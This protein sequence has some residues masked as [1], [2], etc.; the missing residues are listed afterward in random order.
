MV[1]IV[2]VPSSVGSLSCGIDL[3]LPP[4]DS[5]EHIT[6][7][8]SDTIGSIILQAQQFLQSGNRCPSGF[9]G[10]SVDDEDKPDFIPINTV[11]ADLPQR[12]ETLWIRSS[13]SSPFTI[14]LDLAPP[15]TAAM[16][17]V[18]KW[19][20]L[21]PDDHRIRDA[22][23]ADVR[24]IPRE[25]VVRLTV[26]LNGTVQEYSVDGDGKMRQFCEFLRGESGA[27]SGEVILLRNG[28]RIDDDA[29]L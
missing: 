7:Q 29:R 5:L 10:A 3:I 15:T 11:L 16:V 23:P 1:S 26:D 22:N 24:L 17:R 8:L 19:G 13:E 6:V 21:L 18:N 20:I 2:P 28:T 27:N 12:P 14:Y 9:Y 4:N 25:R